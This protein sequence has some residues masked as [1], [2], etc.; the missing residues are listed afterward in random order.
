M[1]NFRSDAGARDDD[2]LAEAKR[3]GFYLI[4]AMFSYAFT[5]VAAGILIC[6]GSIDFDIQLMV[7]VGISLG[8]VMAAFMYFGIIR[9]RSIVIAIFRVWTIVF[10]ISQILIFVVA[11][12]TWFHYG[13]RNPALEA[14]DSALSAG[15]SLV[16]LLFGVF[17]LV[18]G[19]THRW[20]ED[21]LMPR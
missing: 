12:A 3:F 2:R 13:I 18:R 5:L 6:R 1:K 8:V 7:V 20:F 9:R 10:L 17:G 11:L 15:L 21:V 16:G 14:A 4:C 19:V